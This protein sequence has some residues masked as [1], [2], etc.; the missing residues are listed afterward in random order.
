MA[1]SQS[2]NISSFFKINLMSGEYCFGF[3]NYSI[4]ILYKFSYYD[5]YL[6]IIFGSFFIT[7]K[8]IK[9]LK[10]KKKYTWNPIPSFLDSSGNLSMET[11]FIYLSV[12]LSY[13]IATTA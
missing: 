2:F 3:N 9:L 5:D 4:N 6:I 11:F 12:M 7:N 1:S 13:Y 8:K 10:L